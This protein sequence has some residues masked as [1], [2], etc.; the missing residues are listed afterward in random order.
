MIQ[1]GHIGQVSGPFNA[2]QDLLADFGPIGAFTPQLQ[3]PVLYK[4]G[5][6]ADVG[7]V[8][9][10][11]NTNIKIGSTG[12][13]ELD[14]S[15]KINELSFPNGASANTIIDFIYIGDSWRK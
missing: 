2:G 11:N 5:V 3:R 15:V 1:N 9:S 8:I 12:I 6:Q 10:I 7:T 14:D 13:Y 4:I